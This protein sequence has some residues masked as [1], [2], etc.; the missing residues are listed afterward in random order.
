[1]TADEFERDYAQRSGLTVEQL[2]EFGRC[3]RPCRCGESQCP[4][5]QNISEELANDMEARG[6]SLPT[7]NHSRSIWEVFF[8]YRE[9]GNQ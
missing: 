4:G 9:Q 3:V 7:W 8:A 1:M 6:Y 2:R 5:W